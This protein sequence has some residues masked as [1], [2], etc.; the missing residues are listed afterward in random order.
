MSVTQ[1]SDERELDDLIRGFKNDRY[2]VAQ[3]DCVFGSGWYDH[4]NSCFTI[5]DTHGIMVPTGKNLI[6]EMPEGS[7]TFTC[8][9]AEFSTVRSGGNSPL[10]ISRLYKEL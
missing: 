2:P 3:A 10:Y 9:Y 5:P 1:V 8:D 4:E 7:A 6:I